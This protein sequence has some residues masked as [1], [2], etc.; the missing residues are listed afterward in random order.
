MLQHGTVKLLKTKAKM[1]SSRQ[2]ER[3]KTCITFK[4]ATISLTADFTGR[5]EARRHWSDV[6]KC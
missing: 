5:T 4:R 3:K 6:L 2:L 1:R